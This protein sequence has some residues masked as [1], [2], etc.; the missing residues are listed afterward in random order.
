MP[1]KLPRWIQ[2]FMV[3]IGLLSLAGSILVAIELI[4]GG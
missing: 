4:N 3:A 1:K 2:W